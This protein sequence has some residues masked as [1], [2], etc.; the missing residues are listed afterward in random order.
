MDRQK[1]KEY[2][3]L[4]DVALVLLRDTPLFSHVI[5]SKMFEAMGTARPIILG[6]RGES[7]AMLKAAGAGIA[8]PPEDGEALAQ[9]VQALAD[10]AERRIAMGWAGRRFVETQYDRSCLARTMIDVLEEVGATGKGNFSQCENSSGE[11]S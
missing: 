9:A 11:V 3:R 5:P 7:E 4:A 2:W 1:V 8:I 6:V 10:D